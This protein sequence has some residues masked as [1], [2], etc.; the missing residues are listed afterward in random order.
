LSGWNLDTAKLLTSRI[1]P[2]CKLIFPY[3]IQQSISSIIIAKGKNI[4]SPHPSGDFTAVLRSSLSGE[5]S[6]IPHDQ[7]AVRGNDQNRTVFLKATD[8]RASKREKEVMRTMR[9]MGWFQAGYFVPV[10]AIAN[11]ESSSP[12]AP[13][14]IQQIRKFLFR[15]RF[16]A[17]S[18]TTL[19]LG[20]FGLLRN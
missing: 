3:T 5:F 13:N 11:I 6:A 16:Y 20:A 1:N 9:L 10:Y 19:A 12:I 14:G 7:G 2:F 8:I 15:E 17:V 4:T 18:Q